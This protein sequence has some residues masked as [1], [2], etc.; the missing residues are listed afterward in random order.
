M[1]VMKVGQ[2]MARLAKAD[3]DD[4]VVIDT[5]LHCLLLLNQRPGMF[6]PLY[7]DEGCAAPLT[8]RDQEFLRLLRVRF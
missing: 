3:P 2:L 5:D 6:Q 1:A 8:E 4:I 7:V